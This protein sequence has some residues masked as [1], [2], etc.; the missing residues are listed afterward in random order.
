[1][2]LFQGRRLR[3]RAANTTEE[4]YMSCTLKSLNG[5]ILRA[6]QGDTRSLD[7]GPNKNYGETILA[8]IQVLYSKYEKLALDPKPETY[9]AT[10]L[11][12]F[13]KVHYS[14]SFGKLWAFRL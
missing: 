14:R 4:N 10:G 9:V 13:G 3:V 12:E 6:I 5:F 11:Q 1:M 2:G 8:G 7:Y